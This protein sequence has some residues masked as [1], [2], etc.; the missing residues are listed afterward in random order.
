[1]TP[2][3]QKQLIKLLG[4]LEWPVP[5]ELFNALCEN[6]IMNA[7]E[8]AVLRKTKDGPEIL[9][10][11][12][13]DKYFKGWHL[14]GTIMMPGDTDESALKRLIVREV[15]TLTSRFDYV[16]RKNTLKG[17]GEDEYARGQVYANL[18]LCFAKEKYTGKG[19][20]F[21]INKI[22]QNTLSGHKTL[23]KMVQKSLKE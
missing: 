12:R 23:I 2:A 21:P 10:F 3:E 20:F 17:T 14:P 7:V 6:L 19:K 13:E 4:K 22:P 18:Y 16:D 9:L 11:E 8:L 1:M 15:Q 5:L